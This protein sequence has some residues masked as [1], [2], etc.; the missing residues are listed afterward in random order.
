MMSQIG[1]HVHIALVPDDNLEII[2]GTHIR[3][4]NE[5][6]YEIRKSLNGKKP[7]DEIHGSTKIPLNAGDACFF[8]AW[9]LHRGN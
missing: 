3:W 4:D 7:N 5:R 8:S 6:E 2:S 9:C 1:V